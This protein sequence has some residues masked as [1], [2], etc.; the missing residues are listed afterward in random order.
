MSAFCVFGMT[1]PLAKKAAEQASKT[2][3]AKLP[4]N[5][6]AAIAGP[7]IAEWVEAKAAEILKGAKPKQVS[8]AFDAPQFAQDWID[9]A[10]RTVKARGLRV[11]VRGEKTDKNGAP[12]ISKVT[13]KPVIGWVPYR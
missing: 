6:R 1:E 8:G 4:S 2:W 3:L 9:L 11:M 5:E 7:E 10:K 12:V 13:K